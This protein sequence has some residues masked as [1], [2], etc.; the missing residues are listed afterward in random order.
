MKLLMGLASI[1]A[2]IPL[3]AGSRG[4]TFFDNKNIPEISEYRESYDYF[5]IPNFYEN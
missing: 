5:R 3:E 1:A 2:I 4:L